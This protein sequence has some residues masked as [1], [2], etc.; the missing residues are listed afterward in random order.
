M[1]ND[2]WLNFM[3]LPRVG[4][5]QHLGNPLPVERLLI[6][7][8]VGQQVLQLLLAGLRHHLR[9]GVTVLIWMLTE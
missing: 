1:G 2:W 4:Q 5:G 9:Q 3:P 7:P 6:P 8:H